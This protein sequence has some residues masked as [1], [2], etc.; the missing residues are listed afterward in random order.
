MK[1]E[2]KNTWDMMKVLIAGNDPSVFVHAQVPFEFE[3]AD[4]SAPAVQR[5][6]ESGVD[7]D[8]F[9]K[10]LPSSCSGCDDCESDADTLPPKITVEPVEVEPMTGRKMSV[11]P[12]QRLSTPVPPPI[13][14]SRLLTMPSVRRELSLPAVDERAPSDHIGAVFQQL[15]N[16]QASERNSVV[17]EDANLLEIVRLQRMLSTAERERDEYTDANEV[18]PWY[19]RPP[20]RPR[21]RPSLP[22]PPAPR[23]T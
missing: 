1:S 6:V 14:L 5:G 9:M 8:E 15:M 20:L 23:C 3:S 18:P 12:S 4:V 7:F 2:D 10:S 17:G 21:P 11:F 16:D 13:A 19:M 22:R